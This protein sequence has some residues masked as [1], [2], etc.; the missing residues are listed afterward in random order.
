MAQ[1]SNAI[2]DTRLNEQIP[3]VHWNNIGDWDDFYETDSDLDG[4]MDTFLYTNNMCQTPDDVD[5]AADGGIPAD[6]VNFPKELS[7]DLINQ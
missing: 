2:I 1:G 6:D 3:G 4:N 5:N 7:A